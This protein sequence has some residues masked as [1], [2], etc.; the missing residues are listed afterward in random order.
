MVETIFCPEC[1]KEL[2]NY[3]HSP[4]TGAEGFFKCDDC[5]LTIDLW[6]D[7][8][9]PV[10]IHNGYVRVDWYD[11]NEGLFGD[12]NPDNPEDV[13]LLRFDVYEYAGKPYDVVE[14]DPV[15]DASY[16]TL[17][18]AGTPIERLVKAAFFILREYDD[19]LKSGCSVKK[20]G[21]GLSWI[22]A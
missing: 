11:C 6:P 16:C 1:G 8:E 21:E 9:T 7:I 5:N 20:L 15:E 19:A 4:Y 12:Y 14:W 2:E 22:E 10:S 13:H 17:T 18:S 3:G